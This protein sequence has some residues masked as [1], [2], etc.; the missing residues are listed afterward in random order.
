MQQEI[1]H[2]ASIDNLTGI[3]NRHKFEELFVLETER[4]RRFSL[5]LSLIFIR[6]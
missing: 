5:P 2:I 6:H 1:E 3:Y 4:S